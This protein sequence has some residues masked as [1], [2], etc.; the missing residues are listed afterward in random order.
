MNS[1]NWEWLFELPE[2]GWLQLRLKIPCIMNESMIEPVN[3]ISNDRPYMHDVFL[4]RGAFK[5]SLFSSQSAKNMGLGK[6]SKS[7]KIYLVRRWMRTFLEERLNTDFN[8]LH[9]LLSSYGIQYE[10]SLQIWVDPFCY[11]VKIENSFYY[12]TL[13][14]MNEKLIRKFCEDTGMIFLEVSG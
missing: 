12:W 9:F 14:S 4:F 13:I 1:R 5:K 6:L 10:S 7:T 3:S 11:W 2:K 8:R